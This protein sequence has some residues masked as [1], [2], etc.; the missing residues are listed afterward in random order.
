MIG[1]FGLRIALLS[2]SKEFGGA[3]QYLLSLADGLAELGHEVCLFT[4]S[5]VAWPL[6]DRKPRA[7]HSCPSFADGFLPL[8]MA[9]LAGSLRRLR[10]DVLHINLP[11]TYSA[12]FSAMAPLGRV[13][14]CQ[15]VTTEHLSMVGRS[16]RRALLKDWFTPYVQR[17]IAV[18]RATAASLKGEHRLRGEKITVVYNGV[19]P[20][21]LQFLGRSE[22]RARLGVAQEALAVGCV[23]ELIPRK[24][25]RYLVEAI[26]GLRERLG[27]QVQL[28]IV[29]DGEDRGRLSEQIEERGLSGAV[30]LAGRVEHASSLLKAFDLLA[31]PSLMEALPFALLEAMAAGLPVVAS[32]V[33][34]IPEVVTDGETGLLVPPAD[35]G[36]LEQAIMKLAQDPD[37]RVQMGERAQQAVSER[38]SLEVMVRDTVSVY[39]GLVGEG[40]RARQAHDVNRDGLRGLGQE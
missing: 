26:S 20:D 16:R 22:A 40:S 12:S 33:W 24:G 5:S 38:F 1:R 32:S 18:S 36:A 37:L 19:D 4:R 28:V 23:G 31:M 34:G 9:W 15:V 39:E 21:R 17:V 13:M 29:G 27:G 6:Q 2:E 11:S 10:S 3:E 14:G 35:V 7:V 25:Q 30:I 8:R